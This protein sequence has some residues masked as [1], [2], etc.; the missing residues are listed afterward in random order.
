MRQAGLALLLLLA[1]SS[2]RADDLAGPVT[3]DFVRV[4]DGDTVVVDAHVWP[5]HRVRV[6]VRVRGIDAPELRSDCARER[7][8]AETARRALGDFIG[9][10]ALVLRNIGEDK[11]F[12][13]VVADLER[14]DGSSAA[15]ML[16]RHDYAVAYDGGRRVPICS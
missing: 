9:A 1:C 7:E 16:L 3:A 4:I 10:G 2:A 15:E 13:R 5:G 12:G 14:A 11:Y 6:S 8:A